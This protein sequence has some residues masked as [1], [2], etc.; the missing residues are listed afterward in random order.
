VRAVS[1]APGVTVQNDLNVRPFVRGGDADQTQVVMNGLSLLQPYHMGGVFSVFN[2]NTVESI[3]LFRD[4]F[5][6]ENPGAL[7]GVLELKSKRPSLDRARAMANLSLVRGDLFAEIPVVAG[8]ASVYGAAQAFLFNRSLHGML[9]V[10]SRF[11]ED[12]VFQQDIQSYRDRIN[13]PEFQDYHWGAFLSPDANLQAAYAGS[14][15]ADDYA[16]VVPKALN[17]VS[18]PGSGGQGNPIPNVP[19]VPHKEINRS[20]KLSIDSISSVDIAN[21]AHFLN[22]SWDADE[23]NHLENALGFQTQGY[24]VDFKKPAGNSEPLSLSQSSLFLNFHLS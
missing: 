17:I 13:M 12:T 23:E 15:S 1:F 22:F 3:E 4:D 2:L 8:K 9:D 24:A 20:K 16:V 5:P 19:V 11:S 14:F 7:S 18:R 10:T 21:H 6:I